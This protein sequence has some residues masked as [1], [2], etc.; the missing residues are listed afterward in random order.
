MTIRMIALLSAIY[1]SP[2]ATAALAD[3]VKEGKVPFMVE[4]GTGKKFYMRRPATHHFR[5][6]HLAN[7]HKVPSNQ[8][9]KQVT[10]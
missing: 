2:W 7:I 10:R 3:E 9:Q 6:R 4:Q 5:A 1:L 8:E